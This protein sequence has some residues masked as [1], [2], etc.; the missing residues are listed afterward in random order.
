METTEDL[1]VYNIKINLIGIAF[2]T[3]LFTYWNIATFWEETLSM[4]L[5]WT[6]LEEPEVPSFQLYGKT[7]T[8]N[9][10][11][12]LDSLNMSMTGHKKLKT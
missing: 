2:S 9:H 4:S 11:V 1:A 7:A 10:H 6:K 5:K 12:T 8:Y 3:Y